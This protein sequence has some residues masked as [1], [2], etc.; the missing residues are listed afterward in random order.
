MEDMVLQETPIIQDN[1][2]KRKELHYNTKDYS[3]DI[4]RIM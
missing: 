1:F 3:V 2:G 4:T